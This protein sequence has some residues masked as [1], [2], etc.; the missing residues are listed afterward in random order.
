MKKGTC[1]GAGLRYLNRKFRAVG[2]GAERAGQ[3]VSCTLSALE[4][5]N[6]MGLA[7]VLGTLEPGAHRYRVE[8]IVADLSCSVGG[9]CNLMLAVSDS[10]TKHPTAI[11]RLNPTKET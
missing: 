5:A 10:E 3:R 6:L 8:F 11:L 9:R 2:S 1:S 4:S 7:L